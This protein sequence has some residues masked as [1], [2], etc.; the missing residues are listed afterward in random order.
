MLVAIKKPMAAIKYCEVENEL[1]TL[2]EIVGGYIEVVRFGKYVCIC[3]EEGKLKGK[4][5]NM[6]STLLHDILV[7]TLIF[8]EVSGDEFCGIEDTKDFED[9][10][11]SF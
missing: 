7:G 10:L 8:C 6:C 1:S 11:E 9:A 5:E 2:Q 4:H 3:D